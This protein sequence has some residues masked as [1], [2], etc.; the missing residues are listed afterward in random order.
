MRVMKALWNDERGLVLSA[1]AV[2]LG[3]LGVAGAT[4]GLSAVA[5]SANSEL[6]DVAFAIRS[7]DQSFQIPGQESGGARTAGSRFQQMPVKKAHAQL[8]RQIERDRKQAEEKSEKERSSS[9]DRKSDKP[10]KKKNR[11]SADNEARGENALP[12]T[13]T[14]A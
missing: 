2:V 14:S 8:R 6:E 9:D 11:K 4:V 1:E 13:G 12:A 10:R 3:T 7:L 5:R